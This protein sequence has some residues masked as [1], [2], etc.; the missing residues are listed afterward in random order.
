MSP[1]LSDSV[2]SA[3]ARGLKFAFG[4]L[5]VRV[6][7]SL[8][9]RGAPVSVRALLID[10]PQAAYTTLM[11]TLD[12]LYRKGVLLRERSGRAFLYQPRY[13]RAQLDALVTADALNA[14]FGHEAATLRPALSFLVDAFGT[15]DE[16]LL[17]ELEA[18]VQERRRREDSRKR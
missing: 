11:T 16:K 6:L 15:R 9:I 7:E 2:S 5:E 8:W 3:S 1:L 18:L 13:T 14:F 10:F 4:K 12:R 17:D